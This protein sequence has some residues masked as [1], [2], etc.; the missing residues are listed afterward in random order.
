MDDP[1]FRSKTQLF[2]DRCEAGKLLADMFKKR[3]PRDSIVL[4]IPSGGVP[5]GYCL[6][7]Q[8][9]FP[10]DIIVVRKVPIPDNPEAGFGAIALDGTLVINKGL[11]EELGIDK[12]TI[13][14]LAGARLA[15]VRERLEKFRGKKEPTKLADK[16]L[17]LVDDGLAS[18]YTMLVA[19]RS[20]RKQFPRSIMVAIPTAHD[21][22]LKL[23]SS[24]ADEIYCLNIRYGPFF[25]VADAYKN[26]YDL[27]D[28]E[29]N[30]YLLKAWKAPH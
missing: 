7:R 27:S 21:K 19:I 4:A 26:W 15:E 16:N 6:S 9:K 17:I 29:V 23:L 5:V 24:E 14:T 3:S 22:A 28:E 12:Q 25:A 10:L 13:D 2:N 20:V 8:L 11:V 18:G 30:E 1:T